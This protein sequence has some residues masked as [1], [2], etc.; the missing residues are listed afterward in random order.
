MPLSTTTKT[1]YS[2]K[3][4]K[5]RRFTTTDKAW[6][7]E[8]PG[9]MTTVHASDVWA[10]QI[11]KPA[12]GATT[13]VVEYFEDLKLTEDNTTA[14]HKAWLACATPGDTSTQLKGFVPPVFDQT[15]TVRVFQDDGSGNKGDEIGTTHPSNWTFD[16]ENGVLFFENDPTSYGLQTPFHI[17]VYRYIGKTVKEQTTSTTDKLKGFLR[18]ASETN[19]SAGGSSVDVT[20]ELSTKIPGGN[21]TTPGVVTDPPYNLVPILKAGSRD[22]ILTADGNKV[23][24]RLTYDNTGN[25]WTLSFYY[26]DNSGAEQTYSFEDDTT[27]IWAYQEILRF[28]D[29]P[30]YDESV[31]L[32]SDQVVGDIPEATYD[33]YGKVILAQKD[34]IPQEETETKVVTLGDRR[35]VKASDFELIVNYDEANTQLTVFIMPG[36]YNAN[37]DKTTAYSTTLT[38]AGNYKFYVNLGDG[39][40]DY[41]TASDIPEGTQ[42]LWLV[43]F[44][45]SATVGDIYTI[46]DLRPTY[47]IGLGG[48][49]GPLGTPSDGTYTDGLLDLK[50]TD[51]VADA[52]DDINE[53]LKYLAPENAKDLSG[54][55]TWSNTFITGKVA[56]NTGTTHYNAGDTA[57]IT[58]DTTLSGEL[59]DPDHE[60][61]HA[62][63]GVLKL[64]LNGTVSDS[65][66]LGA[67]FDEANRAGC[68]TYTPLSGAN[69][70]LTVTQ[71]CWYN[72]FP[73]WQKGNATINLS[74]LSMG[75]YT[76][77]VT[78]DIDNDGTDDQETNEFM[79]FVDAETARPG[80]ASGPTVSEGTTV[81]YKYLSGIKFY[82]ANTEFKVSTTSD[83]HLFEYTYV[84]DPIRIT[85][86][87]MT[88]VAVSITDSTV[89]G[90][91]S[92]PNYN[93]QMTITDKVITLN[94][95]NVASDDAKVTVIPRDP[96][97][98]GTAAVE[99]IT[100]KRLVNTYG[101]VSTET[102]ELFQ[103]EQYRLP[104]TA[105]FDDDTLALTG[106]WDSTAVLSD[107]DAQVFNGK[108]IYPSTNYTS[109]YAPAQS[110]SADYSTFS[111]DQVYYRVIH[112]SSPHNSG[113][114][115]LGNVSTSDIGTNVSVYIKLPTQTGW[116]SLQDQ[117][118]AATFTGA[119]GDGARTS[120]TQNGS[121]V[122]IGWSSG[123]KSTANSNGRY[124]I[125]IVLHNSGVEITKLIE[126]DW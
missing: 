92:P 125:K 13:S 73:L 29:W 41:T 4:I 99:S 123:T 30:V 15:Y 58:R 12:P 54:D 45:P 90:V 49:T 68:Q 116:L 14:N 87:G 44:N 59:P 48:G 21:E 109:G 105:N 28:A 38:S 104:S 103:D 17:Q 16:Y 76:V 72:N 83:T 93:D 31:V 27:I 78:R 34:E 85:M 70:Q 106:N 126:N 18:E 43:E 118:N 10:D 3:K 100:D 110:S 66:D 22:E 2:F 65:V 81:N 56:G 60:F 88:D 40:I 82:G 94:Q 98:D 8:F 61:N 26:R 91:S 113:T 11:P 33:E 75:D 124:Y 57:T 36:V 6:Y 62:D 107:G 52:V 74:S 114:I 122:H 24:G 69:N 84:D 77:K 1:D 46:T 71:V 121:D 119:D 42:A 64:Y 86:P 63:E 47:V 102:E 32:P 97:G 96:W 23:Y 39:T 95:S 115:V 67:N 19:V 5:G 89:T 9:K 117:F 51:K 79:F 53:V 35:I 7:E 120:L 111:G 20:S 80:I 50:P 25:T 37:G 55:I 101:D 108:L 112:S